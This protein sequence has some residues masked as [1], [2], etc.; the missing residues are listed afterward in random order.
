MLG[1]AGEALRGERLTQEGAA[2]HAARQ[3]LRAG[4]D[5]APVGDEPAARKAPGGMERID[6]PIIALHR[7]QLLHAGREM[8]G[9]IRPG[10]RLAEMPHQ[11][12]R[13]DDAGG[14]PRAHTMADG[15]LLALCRF[16]RWHWWR[17]GRA[18]STLPPRLCVC[19]DD[20]APWWAATERGHRALTDIV[21]FGVTGGSVAM[22]P[23]HP[24]RRLEVSL[25]QETPHTGA[26]PG[27]HAI[28]GA[29]GDQSVETPA[30]G[31]TMGGGRVLGRSRE[32]RH[33]RR[34]GKRAADDPSAAPLADR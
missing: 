13:R 7:R 20:E 10:T 5:V 3:G 15:L 32:A 22:Q 26:T 4:G 34:G 25:L 16:P 14:Q 12:A 31:R 23:V 27:P 2:W 28:L 11:L 8:G 18:W 33:P 21:G 9:P 1:R 24:P 30:G 19:A 29:C 17:R 6:H